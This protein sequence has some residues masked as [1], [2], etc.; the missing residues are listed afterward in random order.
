MVVGLEAEARIARWLGLPVEVGG[1]G[2]EGATVAAGR[3]VASGAHA[4]ISFG[5][6]GGLRP[7]L[8]A[9]ELLV[10]TVILCDDGARFETNAAL[11]SYLGGATPHIM[12]AGSRI[13]SRACEKAAMWRETGAAA[14][15][16]E[17]GAVARAAVAH[18]LA[19]ACLRAV[20]D[21]AGDDLP[22]AAVA[23]LDGAGRIRGGAVAWSVLSHPSQLGALIALAANAAA[24][25]RA[26]MRRVRII[27]A[28]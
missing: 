5:L 6:C 23:A 27:A 22:P 12:L 4:L 13:L 1:G 28:P 2:A 20:C 16:L 11:N 17:S 3:L 8:T 9:G 15:D 14:V 21:P 10:P 26:L 19:H 18:G 24:A 25:R 7:D